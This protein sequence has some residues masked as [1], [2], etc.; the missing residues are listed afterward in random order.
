MQEALSKDGPVILICELVAMMKS[1]D[2]N[3]QL[4]KLNEISISD[5]KGGRILL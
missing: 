3:S 5:G 1:I 2:S 4:A